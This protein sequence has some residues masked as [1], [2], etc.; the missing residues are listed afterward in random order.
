MLGNETIH[1]GGNFVSCLI[2][3]TGDR[4]VGSI[5][6]LISLNFFVSGFPHR[7]HKVLILFGSSR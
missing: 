4:I 3:L 6:K 2:H 5:L 7:S 1:H